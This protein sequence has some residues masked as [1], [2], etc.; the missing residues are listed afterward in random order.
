[1]VRLPLLTTHG[2]MRPMAEIE[3]EVIR[4]A[5]QHYNGQMSEVARKL[6]IGR[7]T[8]TASSR[9]LEL[10]A[11]IPPKMKMQPRVRTLNARLEFIVT[12]VEAQPLHSLP[13]D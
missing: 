8:F 5:I 2:D 13:C 7:S 3:E 11:V 4:R 10:T 12:A 6:G 1:M 9:N